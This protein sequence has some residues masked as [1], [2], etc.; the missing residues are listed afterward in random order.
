MAAELFKAV[1]GLDMTLIPYRGDAPAVTDLLGGQVPAAFGGISSWIEH[2]RTGKLRALGVASAVRLGMLPNVPTIGDTLPGYEASGW[3][4][5]VAPR[6]TPIEIID[7][8]NS[9]INAA[10]AD[11]MFRT[12]L[13][14]LGVTAFATSPAEFANHIAAETEKWGKLIRAANIKPD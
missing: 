5:V 3:C 12:R 9:E 8:L 10:V 11:P 6:N 2:I 1:A 7:K 13:A 4:G 14:D